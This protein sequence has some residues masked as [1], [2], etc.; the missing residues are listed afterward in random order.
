MVIDVI[1]FAVFIY[2]FHSGYS[3]GIIKMVFVAISVMIG[4]IA[5]LKFSPFA[6][7]FLEQAI[8]VDGTILSIMAFAITFLF[9]MLV[10]RLLASVIENA[11]DAVN[12]E[13]INKFAGGAL[14]AVVGVLVYSGILI[15]INKAHLL[16]PEAL[17]SSAFY[18]SLERFPRKIADIAKMIFPVIGDAWDST[19]NTL[20]NAKDALENVDTTNARRY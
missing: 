2:T 14:F 10:I 18:P 5:A 16:T 19:V 13:V 4:F 11:V 6:K 1:F 9:V 7:T 12:L 15:F 20:D 3:R 8:K 17:D